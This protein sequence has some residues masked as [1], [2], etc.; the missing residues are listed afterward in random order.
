MEK[1]FKQKKRIRRSK[2]KRGKFPLL[3]TAWDRRT[4]LAFNS[5]I[6]FFFF[7]ERENSLSLLRERETV[8]L[9]S[10]SIVK[11]NQINPY[12]EEWFNSL[13]KLRF[14]SNDP[15]FNSGL[16]SDLIS[17]FRGQT[18]VTCSLV[19]FRFIRAQWRLHLRRSC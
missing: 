15:R 4:F 11:S 18:C 2:D 7:P 3:L 10:I 9:S 12:S 19:G 16:A 17:V 14:N 5:S 13:F 1:R 6:P 8:N